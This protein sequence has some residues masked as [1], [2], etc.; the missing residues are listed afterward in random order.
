MKYIFLIL[1]FTFCQTA[2]A[3]AILE[4]E[5]S[6]C[7]RIELYQGD[8]ILLKNSSKNPVTLTS[9]VGFLN[10][11]IPAKQTIEIDTSNINIPLTLKFPRVIT[12]A[13]CVSGSV[14]KST[15]VLINPPPIAIY[16]KQLIISDLQPFD[17]SLFILSTPYIT[18]SNKIKEISIMVND[19]VIFKGTALEYKNS[20]ERNTTTYVINQFNCTIIGI[21][22]DPCS[23]YQGA[24]GYIVSRFHILGEDKPVLKSMMTIEVTLKLETATGSIAEYKDKAEYLIVREA[25]L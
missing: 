14:S 22:F 7:A 11:T 15:S 17:I 6:E 8:K 18:Y 2:F 25:L 23:A 24:G 1:F 21:N 12:A 16:P 4:I 19:T 13:Q 3:G 9:D 5:V 20:T 10:S